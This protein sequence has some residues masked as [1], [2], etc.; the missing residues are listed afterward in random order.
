MDLQ[1]KQPCKPRDYQRSHNEPSYEVSVLFHDPKQRNG[2]SNV[3]VRENPV[4]NLKATKDEQHWPTGIKLP[5]R[6]DLSLGHGRKTASETA[7]RARNAKKR[8]TPA[9]VGQSQPSARYRHRQIEARIAPRLQEKGA[10]KGNESQ[11]QDPEVFNPLHA[12]FVDGHGVNI[13]LRDG[14]SSADTGATDEECAQ[15]PRIGERKSSVKPVLGRDI[16]L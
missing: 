10:D 5:G 14:L 11:S 3:E 13:E 9:R 1:L 16:L 6:G 8:A 15:L 2:A 7:S 12:Y 4:R